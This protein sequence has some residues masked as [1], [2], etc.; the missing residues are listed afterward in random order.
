MSNKFWVSTAILVPG[1]L[2]APRVLAG[3]TVAGHGRAEP[4]IEV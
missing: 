3:E 1:L 4:P 2:C